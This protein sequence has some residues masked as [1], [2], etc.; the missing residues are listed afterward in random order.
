MVDR[1]GVQRL[2]ARPRERRARAAPASIAAPAAAVLVIAARAGSRG[3]AAAEA[4]AVALRAS[5]VAPGSV[6]AT[7]AGAVDLAGRV[8]VAARIH[9][10]DPGA[11]R[12]WRERV[13]VHASGTSPGLTVP[14]RSGDRLALLRL[15]REHSSRVRWITAP[16]D[17]WVDDGS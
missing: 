6:V 12:A 3:A 9:V 15:L 7:H 5:G 1:G 11:L 13:R 2:A 17:G 14:A 16:S 10:L 4:Y 8:A